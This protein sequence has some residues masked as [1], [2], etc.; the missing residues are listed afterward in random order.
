MFEFRAKIEIIG[1]NPFVFVP[2]EILK[3]ILSQAGKEKG[4]IPIKGTI[5]D[6][7]YKQTLVKYSGEWRL[8]INTSMLKN[9]PKRIGEIIEITINFDPEKREIEP[10]K[11]FII[12]L[13]QNLEAKNV[14][15]NLSASMKLE[16]VRYLSRLKTEEALEKNIKKSI[17][18]LLGKEKFIGRNK[19]N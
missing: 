17:Q 14:F 4:N 13:N 11:K 12:A 7:V 10:P 2:N 5:N 8:Y 9:S 19:P 3:N 16:I 1:I 6:K 15:D 18:F